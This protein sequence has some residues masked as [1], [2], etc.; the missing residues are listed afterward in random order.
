[1]MAGLSR[2]NVSLDTFDPERF[3]RLTR[4]GLIARTLR[5]IEAAIEAEVTPAP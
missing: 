2:I 1:M 3:V 4:G 5:G